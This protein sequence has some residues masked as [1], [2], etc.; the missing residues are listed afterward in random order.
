MY[1]HRCVTPAVVSLVTTFCGIKICGPAQ[2]QST[3][4]I[5]ATASTSLLLWSPLRIS[6]LPDE[7]SDTV[8]LSD[9]QPLPTKKAIR[10]FFMTSIGW[11]CTP[12]IE[13]L[14]GT[15]WVQQIRDYEEENFRGTEP[16]KR[17]SCSNRCGVDERNAS[18]IPKDG[19]ESSRC[20]CDKFCDEY[21]ECCFDFNKM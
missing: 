14:R 15:D 12:S 11:N 6:G 18:D 10:A 1:I 19:S 20:F 3:G 5:L 17:Y 2:A 16:F 8:P 7:A 13:D 9:S 21:G 4:N